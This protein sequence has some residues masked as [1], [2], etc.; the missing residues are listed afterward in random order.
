MTSYMISEPLWT[1]HRKVYRTTDH[2][3]SGLYML[4]RARVCVGGAS[5][6]HGG[7]HSGR[8]TPKPYL[9]L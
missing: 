5:S 3:S 6:G 1:N 4:P 9:L 7:P 8:M 2:A